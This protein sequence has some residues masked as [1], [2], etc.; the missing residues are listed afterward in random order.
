[1]LSSLFLKTWRTTRTAFAYPLSQPCTAVCSGKSSSST[2]T[3][4]LLFLS[5]SPKEIRRL[6]YLERVRWGNGFVCDHCGAPS[7]PYRFTKSPRRLSMPSLQPRYEPHCRH[8]HETHT[9]TALGVVLG[10]LPGCQPDAQNVGRPV[11]AATRTTALRDGFPDSSQTA[12]RHGSS[13]P[14]S[15][16]WQPRIS[17]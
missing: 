14:G 1:M 5:S 12:G 2:R 17:N 9:Y 15:D 3:K 11:L 6:A 7:E 16:W 10:R 13:R 4:R 8:R